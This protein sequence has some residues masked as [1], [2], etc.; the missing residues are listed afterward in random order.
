M[1]RYDVDLYLS[2]EVHDSQLVERN[3]IVQVSHG[4]AFQFGLTTALVLDV[5]GDR[6]ALQLRDYEIST[7]DR[8]RRLWETRRSGMRSQVTVDG[9]PRVIGT[10]TLDAD[11]GLVTASGVLA[12]L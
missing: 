4:G 2:G 3:G 5:Y 9:A 7:A 6:L 12:P 8:G 11:A 1:R 10:A